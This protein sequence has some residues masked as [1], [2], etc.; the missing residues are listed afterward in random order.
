MTARAKRLRF[1]E[2]GGGLVIA[3]SLGKMLTLACAVAV[4]PACLITE[5]KDY[6][7]APSLPPS[8][9]TPAT[10]TLPLDRIIVLDDVGGADGGVGELRF[11]VIVREPN[12]SDHVEARVFVN[13]P[14]AVTQDAFPYLKSIEQV[15][16]NLTSAQPGERPYAFV[17]DATG[18]N[19]VG[20]NKIELIVASGF[21]GS[22]TPLDAR[23]SARV[24]WW[25]GPRGADL[26]A[27]P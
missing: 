5:R 13:R 14:A 23:E 6:R 1:V 16:T 3:S 19:P 15:P 20:C 2:I 12:V 25:A 11:D 22:I 17:V 18:L 9:V 26:A 4:L 7:E 21:I 27:C 24:V 10:A 8:I